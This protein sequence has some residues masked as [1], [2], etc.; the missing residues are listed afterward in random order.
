MW[1]LGNELYSDTIISG[2]TCS[3]FLAMNAISKLVHLLC[4]LMC[5]TALSIRAADNDNTKK[6]E[7][8]EDKAKRR[9]RRRM[10]SRGRST[11]HL[12]VPTEEFKTHREY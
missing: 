8:E 3:K 11:H 10:K 1:E 12:V 4:S 6:E 7:E 5:Y 9:K 2:V